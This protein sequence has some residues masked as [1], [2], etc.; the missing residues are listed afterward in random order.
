[1]KEAELRKHATCSRC[2]EKVLHTG[3]PLFWRVTVERFG[4]DIAAAKRQDGLGRFLG[5]S[6]LA[7]VMGPNQDM[8]TLLMGPVTLTL[9]ETCAMDNSSVA[10]DALNKA[11]REDAGREFP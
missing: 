2:R 6:V 1:M 10:F 4:V 5:S 7:E 8:A 3:L 9:C 11:E